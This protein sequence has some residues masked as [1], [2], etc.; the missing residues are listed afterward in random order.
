MF[1]CP[2]QWD[3]T[4]HG[5]RLEVMS[6]LRIVVLDV[7]VCSIRIIQKLVRNA[8]NF[9]TL[10]ED[11]SSVQFSRS[12]VSQQSWFQLYVSSSPPFL[13]M[14]SA[15]KLNK[16]GDNIQP[17]RTPFPIWNQSVLNPKFLEFLEME[18][19]LLRGRQLWEAAKGPTAQPGWIHILQKEY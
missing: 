4:A 19:K 14:Y 3:F 5:L 17:W 6:N 13:M 15:Y 11:L 10:L 7:S 12:V 9:P 1:I 18:W 2:Q 8:N 16:Q